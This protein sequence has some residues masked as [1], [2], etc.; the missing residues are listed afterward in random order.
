MR[1]T[2]HP[3][4]HPSSSLH[5][6][7]RSLLSRVIGAC[8]TS[9]LTLSLQSG[10]LAALQQGGGRFEGEAAL[11]EALDALARRR[12][13][14]E[15]GRAGEDGKEGEGEEGA[16]VV[17]RRVLFSVGVGLGGFEVKSNSDRVRASRVEGGE[18]FV[19]PTSPGWEG[20]LEALTLRQA[21][22]LVAAVR[23]CLSRQALLEF[24]SLRGQGVEEREGEGEGE[25]EHPLYLAGR[26]YL[27][28]LRLLLDRSY[29]QLEAF[30]IEKMRSASL[31]DFRYL[32]DRYA[33]QRHRNGGPIE[34]VALFGGMRSW[35]ETELFHV[36]A[37]ELR[38]LFLPSPQRCLD[39]MHALLPSMA[40]EGTEALLEEVTRAD[41]TVVASPTDVKG[42]S[43]L[44]LFVAG[45]GE[46]YNS[47][48]ESFA[49]IGAMH[50]LMWEYGIRCGEEAK[51]RLGQLDSQ[52]ISLRY[53]MSHFDNTFYTRVSSWREKIDQLF[54]QIKARARAHRIVVENPL[55]FNGETE[56]SVA[57]EALSSARGEMD[58]LMEEQRELLYY[59]KVLKLSPTPCEE[60][61]EVSNSHSLL[62]EVWAVFGE[63]QAK[64]AEWQ[65]I[66]ITAIELDELNEIILRCSSL[67]Q[68]GSTTLPPNTIVPK[69][70]T[71]IDLLRKSQPVIVALRRPYLKA[72]HWAKI[73]RLMGSIV[74]RLDSLTLRKLLAY[75]LDER[76]TIVTRIAME[77][78]REA[79]LLESL[80]KAR[81]LQVRGDHVMG[82]VGVVSKTWAS[83]DFKLRS[84]KEQKDV[85]VLGGVDEV[86][87]THEETQ[88]VVRAVAASP[89]VG[90]IHRQTRREGR[91]GG[92]S[93]IVCVL[94]VW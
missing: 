69:L 32:L 44:T 11:S 56:P 35:V 62:G 71:R 93:E 28:V 10:L 40:N 6:T 89:F 17:V 54:L 39:E 4:A 61:V 3:L 74:P 27:R 53:N 55:V 20:L 31:D 80:D 51:D 2:S 85:H 19:A 9:S 75:G 64:E 50:E 59:Q 13:E 81:S 34:H 38:A 94:A 73:D 88:L 84:Y 76:H 37:S 47:Y 79:E 57:L 22:V 26:P 49:K 86:M 5:L 65:N 68:K 33:A 21:N 12:G 41:E 70:S 77:A 8:S 7:D 83:T 90:P 63:I 87:A 24:L 25:E 14:G 15:R 48:N 16:E 30:E 67:V 1:R 43:E 91:V 66:L 78:S 42:F 60:V 45:L 82:G 29:S 92:E 23:P 72:Q 58:A 36:D 52:L 18:V 46:S